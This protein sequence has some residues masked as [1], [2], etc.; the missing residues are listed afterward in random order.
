MTIIKIFHVKFL[1]KNVNMMD[2]V[3]YCPD[4]PATKDVSKLPGVLPTESLQLSA[5]SGL[6]A[7]GTESTLPKIMIF[8][9][10]SVTY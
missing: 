6:L 10:D 2:T 9:D 3:M 1:I 8:Q 4:L 7:S 5:P